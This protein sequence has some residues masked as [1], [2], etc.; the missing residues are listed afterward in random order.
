M[1]CTGWI[2]SQSVKKMVVVKKIIS[3]ASFKE[4]V[5]GYSHS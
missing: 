5:I 3:S 1:P 4:W 2:K